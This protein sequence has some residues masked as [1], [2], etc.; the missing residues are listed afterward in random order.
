MAPMMFR[1]QSSL[2]SA[3]LISFSLLGCAGGDDSPGVGDPATG[4][5]GS[6]SDLGE[7]TNTTCDS[8]L[9]CA[10]GVF[11]NGEES[12]FEGYCY[13]GL[14][15]RC[16][17]GLECTSDRCSHVDNR[18]VFVPADEDGDGH[19]DAA[20]LG[21]TDESLGD[22]CDD[23]DP[24]RYP[25]NAERC[26]E[27]D[28]D[29]DE[30][31]DA[32]T[33]GYLDV[34]LDGSM[35]DACCNEDSSG[36]KTCGSDCDD[37]EYR[38][39]PEHPEICDDIDND[40]DGKVDVNTKEV[41]WYP[42]S[43]GD[44]YGEPEKD[45]VLSCAPVEGHALRATDCDD[46]AAAIHG[47][48]LEICDSFDNDCD[49]EI[50]ED[51]VC[52]CAPQGNA[53]ACACSDKS[54]GVQSCDGG[55]W[56]ACDCTECVDG[57]TDCIGD[58]LPR[59]CVAGRYQVLS[60]CIGQ[61]PFCVE[62]ECVCPDGTL[63]CTTIDDLFPP[64]L[65]TASPPTGAQNVPVGAKLGVI[66]SEAVDAVSLGAAFMVIDE[67][68]AEVTGTLA[69]SG[70]TA[71]FTPTAPFEPGTQYELTIAAGL[72]DLAGNPSVEPY[73]ST[74]TTAPATLPV[75][76][77]APQGY[78]YSKPV[79]D[80][81]E[82][83]KV[84]G[85]AR[86]AATE[87][88]NVRYVQLGFDGREWSE[89]VAPAFTTDGNVELLLDDRGWAIALVHVGT[90]LIRHDYQGGGWNL[91][92]TETTNNSSFA[93]PHGMNGAGRGYFFVQSVDPRFELRARAMNGL[94]DPPTL[95]L[96]S[97]GNHSFMAG[98]MTSTSRA[99]VAWDFP[100][101]IAVA[102]SA[103][104]FGDGWTAY[105]N[106][107]ATNASEAC[108]TTESTDNVGIIWVADAQVGDDTFQQIHVRDGD[109]LGNWLEP[110]GS[111][112]QSRLARKEGS[113]R[114]AVGGDDVRHL[115]FVVGGN[116]LRA[117]SKAP[118][119]AWSGETTISV[120]LQN[121]PLKPILRVAKNGNATLVWLQNTPVRDL[122]GARYLPESGW[123][124][125][126]RL[127]GI[128]KGIVDFSVDVTLSGEALILF[129]DNEGVYATSF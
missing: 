101:Q 8:N 121:S 85:L 29:H 72:E 32:S 100:G 126:H 129:S 95:S 44:H 25:G 97:T 96:S 1:P 43:D 78:V 119:G 117:V 28:S 111:I 15:P 120:P 14:A 69:I 113:L 5:G 36:E 7:R 80:V 81:S 122:W 84:L 35:S 65:V 12:C 89:L 51:G 39:F 86:K 88:I 40:C 24:D 93:L 92:T 77:A 94:Y 102:L 116:S 63:D 31:C 98:A 109:G 58:L 106:I 46:A 53:R 66:Y 59:I 34:D 82:G 27:E 115:S 6:P 41:P 68:G 71:V 99:F 50:D 114:C 54:T 105:S 110:V 75:A 21:L 10:D 127:E 52:A 11:C 16:D 90:E 23:S 33:F 83:G 79:L 108:V 70:D 20:C 62:G 13:T 57:V 19:A 76:L 2:P 9:D 3:L 22:D 124:Q 4:L 45:S 128:A 104:D 55:Y 61:T 64:T 125:A 60:A 30:D 87:G 91:G 47:A 37:D 26:D 17:D 123:G 18:C 38:R 48:A 112:V 49:G 67:W 118:G 74:F 56:G 42:D 107:G 73:I 103:A